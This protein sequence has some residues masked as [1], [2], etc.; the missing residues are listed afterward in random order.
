MWVAIITHRYWSL[1]AYWLQRK[2]GETGEGGEY[3]ILI[4]AEG[5]RRAVRN[6]DDGIN[7][8]SITE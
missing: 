4:V 6:M 3:A 7:V 2:G 8:S 5:G 1:P